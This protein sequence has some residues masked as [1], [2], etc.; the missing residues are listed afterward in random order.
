MTRGYRSIGVA[1]SLLLLAAL[2]SACGGGG[3]AATPIPT[4]TPAALIAQAGQATTAVGSLRFTIDLEG[5]AVYSDGSRLF[6]VRTITG[7][8]QR[9]DGALATLKVRG[10]IGVAEFKTVS[11]AGKQYF[12]NPLTRQWQCLPPG[13]AF[14]PSV[15]FDPQRGIG[16]ILQAGI[17]QP[18]LVG[19]EQIEGRTTNHLRG[20]IDGARLQPI[21][22][23]LLG[24]GPVTIDIWADAGTGRLAKLVL[25]DTATD[26]A[27]P[28]TWT[29]TFSDYDTPVEIRAP[30]VCP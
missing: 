27:S 14:D 23:G 1:I 17:E 16:M 30:L 4:P 6:A 20:I 18:A 9:P 29:I 13:A 28:S 3:I 19:Q 24:A 7:D 5:K 21:S 25:V 2:L 22:T 12:T 8:I 15:L 11:L 10:A 26:S